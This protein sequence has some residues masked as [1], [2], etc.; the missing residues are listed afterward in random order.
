MST[1]PYIYISNSFSRYGASCLGELVQSGMGPEYVLGLKKVNKNS[2]PLDVVKKF[3]LDEIIRYAY[4]V[5]GSKLFLLSSRTSA[6][7]F[8]EDA[9]KRNGIPYQEVP[10]LNSRATRELLSAYPVKAAVVCSL[11]QILGEKTLQVLPVYNLH[12]GGL[13]DNRGA[14]P[15]E[16]SV[17]L[18]HQSVAVAVHRM[19]KNIDE[20]EIYTLRE[21]DIT[22]C[23]RWSCVM[24][25]S[26]QAAAEAIGAFLVDWREDRLE[27]QSQAGQGAYYPKVTLREKYLARIVLGYR[28]VY[29]RITT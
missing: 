17:L 18:G 22:S 25:S 29:R 14:N 10:T 4:V 5:V 24:K 26:I 1:Q 27:G 7:Y 16:R 2:S 8:L 13:P 12:A 20:G 21:A 9:A 19:T 11:S 23:F 15:I 3:T 6:S 28:F